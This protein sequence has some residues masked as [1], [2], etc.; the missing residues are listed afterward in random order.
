MT[1][2]TKRTFLLTGTLTLGVVIAFACPTASAQTGADG[3]DMTLDQSTFPGDDAVFLKWEQHYT[4][5]TDGS[6]IRREHKWIKL[7][8]SRP[9]G[10]FGDPRIDYCKGLDKLTIHTAQVHRANGEAYP[11]APYGINPVGLDAVSGW[12]EYINWEQ[13]VVSFGGIENNCV[14]ELDYEIMTNPGVIPWLEGDLRLNQNYPTVHRLVSI[15]IPAGH[16]LRFLV[17]GLSTDPQAAKKPTDDGAMTY[18]W[19]F[20]NLPSARGESQSLPWQQR[21]GRLQFTSCPSAAAWAGAFLS[22]IE[23]AAVPS[24]TIRKFAEKAAETEMIPVERVRKVWKKLHDT[25]N[26]VDSPK[27]YRSLTCRPATEVYQTNYG[28]PLEAAAL[29]TAALRALD[30]ET[31]L[32]TGLDAVSG[33]PEVPT[34]SSF[35]GIVIVVNS[36]DGKIYVHPRSGIFAN[37]GNWGRHHLLSL[38][39][40]GNIA[41]EYIAARG[42][43]VPS[44]LKV[45][46]NITLKDDGKVEGSLRIILTGASYDPAALVTGGSQ[47]SL[48]KDIAKRVLAGC[49]VKKHAIT[50]LSDGKLVATA[51]IVADGKLK[52][53]NKGRLFQFGSGPLFLRSFHLPLT[54]SDRR[55][56]IHL[57]GKFTQTVDITVELPEKWHADLVPAKLPTV[58]GPWGTISQAVR[59]SDQKVRLQ[60]IVT[61]NADTISPA[62][63]APLREAVNTLKTNRSRTL[64]ATPK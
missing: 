47:A 23:K 45:S 14:L 26:Y 44:E 5:K 13:T 11:V 1:N 9:I 43:E 29:L 10:T 33:D 50:E 31:T 63:F 21:C 42:E 15:T 2:H 46:G 25:F 60:Q 59:V 22:P 56:D 49:K 3:P 32:T 24:D 19:L 28:N 12:P 20:E 54:R 62:D 53:I 57:S 48:V 36:P 6:V 40:K 16:E 30:M 17:T 34:R 4:F 39:A 7:F 61:I 37:P 35:A 51:E 64:I 52:K 38:D 41:T 58:T 18:E 55:T 8:D 27:T